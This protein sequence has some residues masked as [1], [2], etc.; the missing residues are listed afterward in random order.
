MAQ[1]SRNVTSRGK[2]FLEENFQPSS[3]A[4]RDNNDK[5][6][7]ITPT[8]RRDVTSTSPV[9]LVKVY[10]ICPDCTTDLYLCVRP[11][12]RRVLDC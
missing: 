2:E 3:F 5:A 11:Y 8:R 9:P 12:Y 1:L 6:K 7:T 10:K 4:N